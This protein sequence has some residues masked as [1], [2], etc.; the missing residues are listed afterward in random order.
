MSRKW[1]SA[2]SLPVFCLTVGLLLVSC[3]GPGPQKAESPTP[4]VETPVSP[5][6]PQPEAPLGVIDAIR[7]RGELRV[8]MQVGYV[9]FQMPGPKG[10]LIGFDVDCAE[11]AA[12]ALGVG[13]RIVRLS[14]EELIPALLNGKADVVMSG[15]TITPERNLEVVFTAPVIETGRMFLVHRKNADRFK[16][17]SDFDRGNVFLVTRNGGLGKLRLNELAPK[18]GVREFADQETAITE[19]IQGRAQA[20]IDEEFNVRMEAAKRSNVLVGVFTPLTHESIAWAIRPG[21]SHWLNWLDNLIRMMHKDGSLENLR[22]K[23][24]Q[25]YYLDVV[26]SRDTR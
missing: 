1:I 7:Q 8:A 18:A 11:I 9:P 6:H 23:W 12:H 15:M 26:G 24:M 25:D 16:R 4:S 19:V 13:L 21:D 10:S 3:K 20:Y 17:L 22:T 2:A 14:W 5:P